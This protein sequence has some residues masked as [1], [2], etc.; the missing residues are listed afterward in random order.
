MT[1]HRTWTDAMSLAMHRAHIWPGDRYRVFKDGRQWKV[2]R[3]MTTAHKGTTT[4][5][6]SPSAVGCG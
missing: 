4:S 5:R 3:T 1:A 6:P 2:A